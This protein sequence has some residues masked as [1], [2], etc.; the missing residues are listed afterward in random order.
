MALPNTY[1]RLNYIANTGSSYIN[2]LIKPTGKTKLEIDFRLTNTNYNSTWGSGVAYTEFTSGGHR[3]GVNVGSSISI[4]C[5]NNSTLATIPSDTNRHKIIVNDNGNCYADDVLVGTSV[6][7]GTSSYNLPLF[8][9]MWAGSLKSYK[10]MEL[11]SCQISED[12]VLVRN[13]IPAMRKSDSVVGLYD[14][15]NDVFYTNAGSGSFT[16][17]SIVYE[18]NATENPTDSGTITGT[19]TYPSGSNMSLLANA[20]SGYLFDYWELQDY[21]KLEYIEA[22]GTQYIDTEITNN[23]NAR[24]VIDMEWAR[25]TGD[26]CM[27]GLILASGNYRRYYAY[28]YNSKW[29]TSKDGTLITTSSTP[30]INTPYVVDTTIT[31]STTSLNV[32]DTNLYS[33]SGQSQSTAY[34]HSFFIFATNNKGTPDYYAQGKVKSCQIYDATTGDLLGNFIPVKQNSTNEVGLLN[35]VDLSF[36]TNKGTGTFNTGQELGDVEWTSTDNPL[37]LTVNSDIS[38]IANFRLNYQITLTYDNTLGNATYD[39]VSGTQIQLVATPNSNAQFKG[40]YINSIPISTNATYTYTVLSDVVIEARFERVWDITTN[41]S[42]NGS[43]Q[44]TRGSDRNDVVFSVIADTNNHFVKYV[45]DGV[46]YTTTP[47]TLY[48]TQDTTITAY[49]E[50]NERYHITV[51]S[52]FPYGSFYISDNDVFAGTI[53][54]I[55]ARPFPDYNFVRWQDG[56]LENPRQ[57]EVNS[58]ITLVAEYQRSFETNGIYQYRCYIKD[59]LDLTS[60]PKAFMVVDTFDISTDLLT[61]A[62]SSITVMKMLSDIDEGDVLVLYDPMGTTLYTGVINSIEDRTI[63][64]SQMQSFYKGT[65]IYNVSPQDF[66]EHEIAVLLQDY[67]DGKLYRSSYIDPLVAQRLG[68]ITIDYVGTTTVNLPT[69]LDDDGNEQMTTYDMEE[70]IYELYQ[71]YSIKFEFEINISGTNYVHIK[72]PSYEAIKVGNNMFAI[73]DMSPI[74]EIEETNKLVIYAQDKTYRTT[75][76]ATKNSI[77][78]APSTTANRFNITNTEVVFSDDPVEDLVASN[79]PSQMF[80]HKLTFTLIIRNFLYQ[81]GDFNLGGELDIYHNDDYYRSVL[82]GYEI[83]KQSN[84]NIT[85]VSFVCGTVRI[86]LTKMLTLGKV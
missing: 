18:V 70:F 71:K 29:V 1:Y 14:D 39:W 55:W 57:I 30:V 27:V 63:N 34:N 2:T 26:N 82:T 12:G 20:N 5:G 44:F 50:E 31:S 83:S 6:F 24:V 53:V 41:V 46:E 11:Y 67:A 28:A 74:T 19:G 35:L 42:G 60:P 51:N 10:A 45:V 15:V 86:A 37:S 64:C 61:N 59:Q 4:A 33:A 81:F 52:N 54:T 84:Q 38:L 7:T 73:Q 68:G 40:W 56:V 16:Y 62:T 13:F 65:W 69:D 75:Y 17:G 3:F 8:A 66:L 49:F 23:T 21:T 48:L 77:V 43:I 22:T 79:L 80:N 47:L 25:V 72:V 76:I 32:N 85:E 78:E 36:H 58:D 9:C